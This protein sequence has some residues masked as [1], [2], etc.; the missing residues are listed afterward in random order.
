MEKAPSTAEHQ[1]SPV[2]PENSRAEVPLTN[3]NGYLRV[4]LCIALEDSHI[5]AGR[6]GDPRGNHDVDLIYAR[7]ARRGA[8][9]KHCRL[10]ACNIYLNWH[11]SLVRR[12]RPIVFS[13][14]DR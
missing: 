11:A 6:S 8:R 10:D 14:R 5:R 2:Y 12:T 9:V 3:W 4:G 7:K 1:Q 13:H